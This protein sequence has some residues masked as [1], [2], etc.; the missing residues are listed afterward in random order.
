MRKLAFFVAIFAMSMMLLSKESL[1]QVQAKFSYD[2]IVNCT[3]PNVRDYPIHYDGT[4]TLSTDK[5]ASLSLQSN[6][7]GQ[8]DYSVKLGGRPAVAQNGS[9]SVR[10]LNRKTL[11]AVREYPN[12]VIV[13]DLRVVGASCS[14]KVEHRLKPGKRQYTFTTSLG[15]AY[16]DKPRITKASCVGI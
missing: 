13:V 16:C 10:V 12:N 6:I 11:R 7:N 9:A 4:G 2:A 14:V 1:A 15:L 5:G 3:N 8:E